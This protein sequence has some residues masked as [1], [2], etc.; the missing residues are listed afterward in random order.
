[1]GFKSHWIFQEKK[2]VRNQNHL[3]QF[4]YQNDWNHPSTLRISWWWLLVTFPKTKKIKHLNKKPQKKT[5]VL[6][7]S[8]LLYDMLVSGG[9]NLFKDISYLSNETASPSRGQHDRKCLKIATANF[10]Q[11][12]LSHRGI[13]F[14][15]TRSHHHLQRRVVVFHYIHLLAEMR[16]LFQVSSGAN[17]QKNEK[18]TDLGTRKRQ[19]GYTLPTS[20][21][22]TKFHLKVPPLLGRIC[23]DML[24]PKQLTG[25]L[26]ALNGWK[27]GKQKSRNVYHC[28]SPP[29]RYPEKPLFRPHNPYD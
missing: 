11:K 29:K 26:E 20:T 4:Q 16:G 14:S 25:S 19:R 21:N 13:F 7:V 10:N 23:W 15:W 5:N 2:S 6:F 12:I 27:L 22:F 24:D 8:S 18:F 17:K 9:N 28:P 1:M 3:P